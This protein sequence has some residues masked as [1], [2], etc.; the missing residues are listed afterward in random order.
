MLCK[1]YILTLILFLAPVPPLSSLVNAVANGHVSYIAELKARQ[2]EDV[3]TGADLTCGKKFRNSVILTYDRYAAS[4][5][6]HL[7]CKVKGGT[8]TPAKFVAVENKDAD[9]KIVATAPTKEA[10]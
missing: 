1:E 6:C 3:K 7:C 9:T 8:V 4:I 5:F 10:V 2:A